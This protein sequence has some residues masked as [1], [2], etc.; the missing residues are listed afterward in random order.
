MKSSSPLV[1]IVIP[2][3]TMNSFLEETLEYLKKLKWSN[4]EVLVFSNKKEHISSWSKVKCIASGNVGPAQKRDLAIRYG[5]GEFFAFIDDD[6]FP[7]PNWLQRAIP[8]FKNREIAAVGG[9]GV[10]PPNVSIW[11]EASGWMSA[12]PI[13]AGPY[14]Y[15]FIPTTQKF[16]DDYPSMNLIVRKND[17]IKIGG[18]DSHYYPGEDTKLCLDL[19]NLGKKIIYEPQAIVFHHRRPLWGPHLKQNGNF[20]LH[21]GFFARKLPQTSFRFVYFLPTLL[22]LTLLGF[23]LSFFLP[24]NFERIF[25]IAIGFYLVALLANSLWVVISSGSIIHGIIS[26]ISVFVTH[27]WYGIRFIQGFLFTNQ[28]KQ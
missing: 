4:L 25:S 3:R 14:G 1:T 19:V 26:I 27:V 5:K 10:T 24:N 18:F 9:P 11:E 7:D 6:A 20:G 22:F 2:V 13:G 8:H 12:S 23:V 15:R 28:L 21:R 16:V 17:F